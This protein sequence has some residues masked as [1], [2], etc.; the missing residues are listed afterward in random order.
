MRPI[1]QGLRDLRDALR[2]HARAIANA[3]RVDPL[4]FVVVVLAM[5]GVITA[6]VLVLLW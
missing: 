1:A 4:A 5:A 6:A 3:P 2:T